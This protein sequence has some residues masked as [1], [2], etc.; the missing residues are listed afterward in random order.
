MADTKLIYV[1]VPHQKLGQ[2]IART[3]IE[4]KLIACANI[5]P[6]HKAIYQW[7]GSLC[8]EEESVMI[9]KTQ[10]KKVDDLLVKLVE[11]HPYDTPCAIVLDPDKVHP[12]FSQWVKTQTE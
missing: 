3:L 4:K 2:E 12:A 11:I 7:E 10:E 1:T 5:L 8:E 6:P 9:L